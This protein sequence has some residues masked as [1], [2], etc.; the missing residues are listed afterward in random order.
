MLNDVSNVDEFETNAVP[1]VAALYQS[2]TDPPAAV[3]PTVIAPAPHLEAFTAVGTFGNGF[4]VTT[5][6]VLTSDTQPPPV[7]IVLDSA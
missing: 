4:T 7:P 3:A 6:G 2:T 1:S 5:Y